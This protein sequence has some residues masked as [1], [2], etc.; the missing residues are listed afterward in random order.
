VSLDSAGRL[1]T[2]LHEEGETILMRLPPDTTFQQEIIAEHAGHPASDA[3]ADA[4]APFGFVWKP[5]GDDT[6]LRQILFRWDARRCARS[7]S[8]GRFDR[9]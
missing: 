5:E 4:A 8:L 9:Q 7:D 6:T 2:L 1:D 3:A